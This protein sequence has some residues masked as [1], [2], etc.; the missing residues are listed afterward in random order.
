VTTESGTTVHYDHLVVSPC[1]TSWTGTRPRNGRIARHCFGVHR[2]ALAPK[3]VQAIE[4]SGGIRDGTRVTG[5]TSLVDM[6]PLIHGGRSATHPG[7][8]LHFTNSDGLRVT[9]FIVDN[10]CGGAVAAGPVSSTSVPG[11]HATDA[12]R[13]AFVEASPLLG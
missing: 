4:S 3:T 7:A 8:Q 9:A 10:V 12:R 1:H 2:Y 6:T 13:G 5:A 11:F